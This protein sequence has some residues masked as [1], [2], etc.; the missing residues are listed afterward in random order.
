MAGRHYVCTVSSNTTEDRQYVVSTRSA[1]ACAKE[2]GRCEGGE[3]VTVRTLQGK[4][5]SRVLWSMEE[6]K[7]YNVVV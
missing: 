6:K 5:L 2:Y 3:S 4:P 1:M 7:Y